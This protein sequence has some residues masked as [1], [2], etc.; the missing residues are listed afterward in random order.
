MYLR[1][2]YDKLEYVCPAL[3]LLSYDKM[4]KENKTRRDTRFPSAVVALTC[5]ARKFKV[6]FL[7]LAFK[8]KM[9][10]N[11]WYGTP[12]FYGIFKALPTSFN[13]LPLKWSINEFKSING[14]ALLCRNNSIR[15]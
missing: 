5:E 12:S 11:P 1:P 7:N 15:Q 2:T 9:L 4:W 10:I 8:Q 13:H 14:P 6:I 3:L